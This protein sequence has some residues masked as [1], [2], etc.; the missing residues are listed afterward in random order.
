MS[1]KVYLV[2]AKL[3]HDTE[4]WGKMDPYVELSYKEQWWKSGCIKS[5]GLEPKWYNLPNQFMVIDYPVKDEEITL[6]V[7]DKDPCKNDLVG[8]CKTTIQ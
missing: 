5:A 6:K 4:L 8:E 3:T 2:E 1:V 7:F